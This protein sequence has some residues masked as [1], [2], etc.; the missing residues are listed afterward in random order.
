MKLKILGIIKG[1]NK[2]G[3]DK[4]RK[5]RQAYKLINL[6]RLTPYCMF[7]GEHLRKFDKDLERDEYDW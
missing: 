4:S 5:T 7:I 3:S 1:R 6:G 2:I